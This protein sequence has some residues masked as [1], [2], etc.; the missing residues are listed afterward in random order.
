MQAMGWLLAALVRERD[1][2][3]ASRPLVEWKY[4]VFRWNDR[5]AQ[6]ERAI[7]LA[8]EAGVDRISFWPAI[9]PLHGVSWRFRVSPFFAKLGTR[10]R[11]FRVVDLRE[12][13]GPL[14]RRA[15]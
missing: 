9:I 11:Q 2:R 12:A 3:Q 5:P 13:R 14:P 8:R 1:R 4:V 7:Q 15:P 6:I 10:T